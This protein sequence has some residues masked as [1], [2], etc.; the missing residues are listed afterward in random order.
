[1]RRRVESLIPIGGKWEDLDGW[2][3]ED[4]LRSPDLDNTN[5]T[6]FPRRDASDSGEWP[7][8]RRRGLMNQHQVTYVEVL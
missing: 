5:Y 7:S 6:I 3:C 1:M 4:A 2:S 8:M